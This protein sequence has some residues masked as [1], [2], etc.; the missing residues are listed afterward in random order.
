M[1][2]PGNGT[3][4]T[5]TYFQGISFAGTP[6]LTRL[7]STVNFNF[8]GGSPAPGI[9]N[10]QFSIRWEGQVEARSDELYTFYVTSDDGTRLFVN[11]QLVVNN[12]TDHAATEGSGTIALRLGQRYSIRLEYYENGGDAS[13]TFPGARR[14]E[15]QNRSSRRR[16]SSRV[17]RRLPLPTTHLRLY[18]T[19]LPWCREAQAPAQSASRERAVSLGA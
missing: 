13:A 15:S 17:T 5:G 14:L 1:S 18:L 11:D 2:P 6:L 4:L 3:G 16:N 10:D 9:P 19:V 7:D 8:A 12:F